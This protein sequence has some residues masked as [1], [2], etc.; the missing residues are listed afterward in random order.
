[1]LT[2]NFNMYKNT[3]RLRDWWSQVKAHFGAVQME[4]NGV[5]TS[6]EA[7]IAEEAA[8]RQSL[9]D[10]LANNIED[11]VTTA[12]SGSLQSL[13]NS[14]NAEATVR[15][16]AVSTLTTA[17]N[18]EMGAR[19]HGDT[20]LAERVTQLE[21]ENKQSTVNENFLKMLSIGLGAQL[22]ALY[23]VHG[24][25]LYDGGIFGETMDSVTLNGGVF[26]ATPS[27]TIDFGDNFQDA[28]NAA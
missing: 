9:E 13:G 17:L 24:V 3:T 1:M 23:G 11:Y 12:C 27:P 20:A 4:I 14:I 15:A 10:N 25:T 2:L 21:N 6:L 7:S 19:E 26:T 28:L 18:E 16:S 5:A 22:R 8:R